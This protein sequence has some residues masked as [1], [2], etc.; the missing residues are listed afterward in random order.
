MRKESIQG[1][2][3]RILVLEGVRDEAAAR[4]ET[5]VHAAAALQPHQFEHIYAAEHVALDETMPMRTRL[6]QSQKKALDENDLLERLNQ[7]VTAFEADLLLVYS[8]TLFQSCPNEMLY[9][10]Q[11]LKTLHPN[12]RIGFQ[13]RPF[14][15]YGPKSFFEYTREIHELM[16]EVFAE[17]KR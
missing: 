6:V 4:R 2:P 16:T 13:P 1:M 7:R 5:H 14:E 15:R 10:M 8:G 17:G 9:V 11:T 12:L 3:Y